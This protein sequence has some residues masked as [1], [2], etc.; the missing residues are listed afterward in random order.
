MA[1]TNEASVRVTRSHRHR[2]PRDRRARAWRRRGAGTLSEQ[3]THY[4][5]YC[6]TCRHAKA[7]GPCANADGAGHRCFYCTYIDTEHNA[8]IA[9]Q[10]P[11][12]LIGQ[13][14]RITGRNP[15]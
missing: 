11:E 1:Q 5:P 13:W 2:D 9:D 12:E 14:K 8:F 10:R 15:A 7:G 6:A 4:T 3:I